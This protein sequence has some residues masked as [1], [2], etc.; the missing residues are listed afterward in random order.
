MRETGSDHFALIGESR[1]EAAMPDDPRRVKELFVAALELPDPQARRELLDRECTGDADLRRRLDV[2]LQAH[3]HPESAL[4]RPLAAIARP[5]PDPTVAHPAPPED[6]GTVV[7]GQYKLLES[8]GEGGMGKV[9]VADQ[10]EPI[11]RRVAIKLVK[12]G[13]DSKAVLA[14]FEAERQALAL[15]DHPNIAKVLDAGT[16]DDGRPF[17]AMELVKGTPITA[18]CDGRRLTLR[19]RLELFVP[20]CQAVQHAHQKGIIHR[21]LKPSNVLVALHDE[22]PVPKVIDFGVA[23][24]VGQQLTERTLYTGFG[25]LIGTPAYMAPEQATFNQLD[26]D[27][28][29]D[30]YAL[31][32][33]LY[34][35]LAGSTPVEP[36]RLRKAALDEVLRVVREEEPPRPSAR[37]STAQARATIAAVRQTDPARLSKL[38]RGELDWIVMKALEKDRNRRYDTAN[39]FAAD[40]QRYLAGEPVLAVPPSAGYRLRKFVRRNRGPVAAVALVLAALVAGVVGTTLGLVRA[41]LSRADAV[42][43][44]HAEAQ[45]RAAAVASEKEAREASGRLRLAR[46]EL[47]VNLYAARA[48]L[49]Q[50]AWEADGVARMRELLEEQK[51]RPGEPDLRGFEW[52][53]WDRRANAELAVGRPASDDERTR[54]AG[55]VLSPDG[56]RQATYRNVHT[57]SKTRFNWT[58]KVRDAFTGAETA[59]FDVSLPSRGQ[60]LVD[61]G[62]SFTS[63]S[64]G[65]FVKAVERARGAG[66]DKAHWW[67]FDADTGKGL[68]PHRE[69]ACAITHPAELGSDRTLVAAPVRDPGGA[70]GLRLKL[71]AVAGGDGGRVCDGTFKT[72]RGVAFR[73]GEQEVAALVSTATE[74]AVVK[75]WDTATGRERLSLPAGSYPGYNVAWSPDGAR[76]ATMSFGVR[77]WDAA[78]GRVRLA[79]EEVDGLARWIVFSPDGGRIASL[80][81]PLRFVTLHDTDTGRVRATLKVPDDSIAGVAFSADGDRLVTVSRFGTARAWD[82]T[83]S[84]LPVRLQPPADVPI[85]HADYRRAIRSGADGA[86]FAAAGVGRTPDEGML[87]VWDQT[88]K[89]VFTTTRPCPLDKRMM[90]P[91]HTLALSPDGRRVAWWCGVSPGETGMPGGASAA[92]LRVIDLTVGTELWSRDVPLVDWAAFSPDGRRLAAVLP[93]SPFREDSPAAVKV[94]DAGSGHEVYSFPVSCGFLFFT[95]DGTRLVGL[96]SQTGPAGHRSYPLRVWDLRD[97]SEVPAGSYPPELMESPGFGGGVALSPDGTRLAVSWRVDGTG[98]GMVRMF[99]IPGGRELRPLRGLDDHIGSL[100]FSPDGKRLA[101]AGGRLAWGVVKVWDTASGHD[102]LALRGG[103][104]NLEFS[105]DGHR[106]RAVRWPGDAC[107]VTTWDATP[108]PE[109]GRP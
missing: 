69:A 67:L 43:A 47:Y 40:V 5:R 11:R 106:L 107:E 108:R 50:A 88:G 48:N 55:R 44:R 54:D 68:A 20:V 33:L 61:V 35:L 105:R 72:V 74:P 9:W 53:Y 21:D 80:A 109:P 49:I 95:A 12:P 78:D 65:L 76:L 52:Y 25:A 4:D 39:G 57:D 92:R 56:R 77:V 59:S 36:E 86:R 63:D 34:E 37:L 66:P 27:T 79:T 17:F 19:E 99:E 7:A 45:Q 16:T 93:P 46:D 91:L 15:M 13:M 30:V 60:N 8:V 87:R 24:A 101:A 96:G 71:W 10:L 84:D 85:F 73:P 2:L 26:V 14:R 62:L 100:A 28:R 104:V 82:A 89:P 32:V 94:L 70:N 38:M 51:P 102:L 90:A 97:G 81:P 83:A 18:F 3:D 23:K 58:V 103:G 64:G 75:V 22:R 29:A 1:E 42:S 41:E 6:V 98:E 31:G